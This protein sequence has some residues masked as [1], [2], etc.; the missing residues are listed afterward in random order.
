[1]TGRL[2]DAQFGQTQWV[3]SNGRVTLEAAEI[4]GRITD[5]IRG[6]VYPNG[7]GPILTSPDGTQYRLTVANG[8]ALTATAV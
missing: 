4:L 7:T 8:G 3:D 5:T 6:P 2:R 1:M